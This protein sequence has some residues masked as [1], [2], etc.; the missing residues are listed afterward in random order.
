[1]KEQLSV[2]AS[3]ATSTENNGSAAVEGERLP[4]M[5]VLQRGA[6][7]LTAEEYVARTLPLLEL[8]HEAEVAQVRRSLLKRELSLKSVIQCTWAL[9]CD[10]L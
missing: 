2:N 6:E 10:F 4:Q 9:A 3:K 1:M 7:A 8:E 5:G